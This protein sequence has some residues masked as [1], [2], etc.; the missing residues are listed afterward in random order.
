MLYFN[1]LEVQEDPANQWILD[2][3]SV[4]SLHDHQGLLYHPEVLA[5]PENIIGSCFRIW[6]SK[7]FTWIIIKWNRK[8]YCNY[9]AL[10]GKVCKVLTTSPLFP[11]APGGPT[12][13]LEPWEKWI[14]STRD[15]LGV[16]YSQVPAWPHFKCSHQISISTVLTDLTLRIKTSAYNVSSPSWTTWWTNRTCR[17]WKSLGTNQSLWTRISSV[18]LAKQNTQS[19]KINITIHKELI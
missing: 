13:P 6:K 1:L 2:V 8:L 4:L 3:L 14:K 12:G 10:W 5:A 11:A 17:A 19:I 18:T 16:F 7:K 9:I 15:L